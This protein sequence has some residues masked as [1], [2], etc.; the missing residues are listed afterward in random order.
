MITAERLRELLHYDLE[1][2]VF[3]WRV[4]R[5]GHIGD[6][7]G[8]VYG[9]PPNEGYRRIMIDRRMY[10]ASRLAWLYMTG[11]WPKDQVDH[12]NGDR[13]DNR[14]CNI[15][16]A[17]P[18]QNSQNRSMRTDN[19][20]GFKGVAWHKHTRKWASSIQINGKYKHLGYFA[21]PERA[22][23]AYIFAAWK[24]FGDYARI[25]AAYIRVIRERKARKELETRI[26]WN[27]ANPSPNYMA[28]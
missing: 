9:G 21:T 8:N 22:F 7:A 2:G 5:R 6:V 24:H 19:E 10:Q 17:L 14:F 26:L 28:A 25:D 13:A 27:L 16:E 4:N 18:A 20:S 11:E 12:I 15:R 23:I 3:T 1:T